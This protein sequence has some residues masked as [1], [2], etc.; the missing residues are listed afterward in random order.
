[1]FAPLV[2]EGSLVFLEPLGDRASADEGSSRMHFDLIEHGLIVA[3]SSFRNAL[4]G[5]GYG[6]ALMV[7]EGFF[8]ENRYANFHSYYVTLLTESGLL[9]LLLGTWL[10]VYPFLLRWG[11][12]IP[13]IA[14]FVAF[15]V[16][17]QSTTEP[18]FWLFT[19]LAWLTVGTEGDAI[20]GPQ[21]SGDRVQ[22]RHLGVDEHTLLSAGG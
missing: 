5:I 7:L 18:A 17:Y 6:N 16:F 15:G 13:L 12:F 22:E 8:P 1:M 10:L 3:T 2:R 9:A 4:L 14:G 11:P 20:E 21:K 19:A